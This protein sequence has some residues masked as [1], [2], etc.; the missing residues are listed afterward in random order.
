MP[1]VERCFSSCSQD[2]DALG[3]YVIWWCC[4]NLAV[5]FS[6]FNGNFLIKKKRCKVCS[7]S[8][9][10]YIYFCCV[11]LKVI[12]STHSF[13]FLLG[14]SKEC[15]IIHLA[16]IVEYS[17]IVPMLVGM[18]SHC[19][20]RLWLFTLSL[21]YFISF[22]IFRLSFY[23]GFNFVIGVFTWSVEEGNCYAFRPY[24]CLVFANCNSWTNCKS[25]VLNIYIFETKT[26]SQNQFK[27]REITILCLTLKKVLI[28]WALRIMN[29][30]LPIKPTH[31]LEFELYTRDT[32]SK[33]ED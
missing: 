26:K 27:K 10:I 31:D 12:Q 7:K 6:A 28:N 19:G 14:L 33:Y 24:T 25:C 2:P 8:G 23:M 13:C 16:I 4:L 5:A 32:K 9:Y 29:F 20:D 30:N 17:K 3:L 11:S 18:I 21:V 22:V 1:F 15:E